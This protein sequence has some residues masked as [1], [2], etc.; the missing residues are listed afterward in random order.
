MKFIEPVGEP[1]GRIAAVGDVGVLGA[2][3]ALAREQGPDAPFA[4]LAPRLRAADVG[5]ANFE[6]AVGEPGLVRAGR[7]QEFWQ[8]PD[9]PAA[10][11]RA[12]VHVVS[13]ANNHIMDCGEEGLR[14]TIAACRDA[15]LAAIGAGETLDEARRPWHREIAGRRTTWLAYGMSTRDEAGPTKPGIAPLEP[16]LIREDLARWRAEA[17]VL[18]VSLHWGSMYVDYP[19]PRVLQLAEAVVAA[20]AD[21]VLGHHPHV[22]Q[23]ARREGR[24]LVLY[25]LGDAVFDPGAG[26]LR[27]QVALDTRPETAVFEILLAEQ[28]GLDLHPL[29]LRPNGVPGDLPEP[30]AR[31]QFARFTDI[32]NGLADAARRYATDGASTL[33]RYELQSLGT[34]A[35]RG[36]WDKVF[37]LLGSVRPRHLPLILNGLLRRRSS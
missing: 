6:S 34:W 36:R 12:G 21:V 11:V 28:H 4:T 3:R 35:R 26:E 10:L 1:W 13:L 9:V 32:S 19:A 37:G 30:E 16:A 15:G 25:S 5:F 27:A 24:A 2:V 29:R 23:G 7:T 8:A 14:R 17:D 31:A 20:G 33:M 22:L 18:V